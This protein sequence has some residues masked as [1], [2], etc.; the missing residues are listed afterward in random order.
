MGVAGDATHGRH[1][2]GGREGGVRGSALRPAG[3]LDDEEGGGEVRG[4][5]GL[6]VSF[7]FVY[8]WTDVQAGPPSSR[9]KS[10]RVLGRHYGTRWRPRHYLLSGPV[11]P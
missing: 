3:G 8:G 2:E 4:W 6:R 9:S 11:H 1:L 10:D 5:R 7:L